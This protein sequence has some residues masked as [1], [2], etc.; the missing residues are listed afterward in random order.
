MKKKLVGNQAKLDMNKDGRLSKEDFDMLNKGPNMQGSWIRKH[1]N[2]AGPNAEGFKAVSKK[3]GVTTY[4]NP[5][6][7]VRYGIEREDGTVTV[8]KT[9]EGKTYKG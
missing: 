3:D 9:K 4:K 2:G 5:K 6:G 1:I 7:E 8:L